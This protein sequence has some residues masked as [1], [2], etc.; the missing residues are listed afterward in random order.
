MLRKWS[1]RTALLHARHIMG[2]IA[3]HE[4]NHSPWPR[5]EPMPDAEERLIEYMRY[6]ADAGAKA[7]VPTSSSKEVNKCNR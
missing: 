3:W 4:A 7:T 2:F 1:H 5:D 6:L